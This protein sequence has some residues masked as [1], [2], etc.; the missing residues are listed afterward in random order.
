MK[1][2]WLPPPVYHRYG[3][4]NVSL[5]L[6]RTFTP[7]R[8]IYAIL[9]PLL[10]PCKENLLEKNRGY[11]TRHRWA[12]VIAPS[13]P[14]STYSLLLLQNLVEVDERNNWWWQ[15][16]VFSVC[17]LACLLYL[18]LKEPLTL[19]ALLLSFDLTRQLL[20]WWITFFILCTSIPRRGHDG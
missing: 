10:P 6:F 7:W 16:P 15:Q 17:L 8:S 1:M 5:P 2:K 11:V 9:S 19:N 18:K 12:S 3:G 20:L 14:F 4:W 13:L